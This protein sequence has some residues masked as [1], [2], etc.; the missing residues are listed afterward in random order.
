[1][2]NVTLEYSKDLF[3]KDLYYDETSPT[4]LRWKYP[5]QGRCK[6]LIAGS[7][8]NKHGRYRT[9]TFCGKQYMLHRIIWAITFG[10]V[11][12]NKVIDHVNGNIN[13]N[14][15]GNLRLVTQSDNQR[16]RKI[17]S[18]NTSGHVGI[19]KS[20]RKG[21]LSYFIASCYKNSLIY[22]KKTFSV[23]KYGA[24]VALQMAIESRKQ[25]IID[26][27]EIYSERHGT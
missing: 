5:T 8:N 17:P 23:L 13:D 25:V 14:S 1:M 21:V 10:S 9:V 26:T 6:S 4:Y 11:D 12:K 15:I 3:E 24:D 27:G 20:Y 18:T 7:L 19:Y 2:R 16:N 22:K